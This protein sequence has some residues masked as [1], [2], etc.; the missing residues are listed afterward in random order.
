MIRPQFTFRVVSV[1]SLQEIETDNS[2]NR[3]SIYNR[4]VHCIVCLE[5]STPIVYSYKE[6]LIK[7]IFTVLYISKD[8]NDL[9]SVVKIDP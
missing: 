2:F 9:Q 5:C 8:I 1:I 6:K 3:V 7:I 4:F